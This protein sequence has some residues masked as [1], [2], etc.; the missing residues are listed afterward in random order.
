MQ[1]K[2][3]IPNAITACNLLSGIVGLYFAFEGRMEAAFIMML[4]AGAFD[5]LDGFAARLLGVQSPVGAELDSLS[6]VVSFGVLPA[7]ML[8]LHVKEVSA[9]HLLLCAIP[10]LIAV[11]SAIRL[12]KFNTDD[13]QHFS[14]LGLPTPGAAILCG[15]IAA[16]CAARPDS[17]AAHIFS[18]WWAA[19]VLS[20]IVSVLLVCEIPFFSFKV[21]R[22]DE[23]AA[24][25]GMKRTCFF[26]I[27]AVAVIIAVVLSWHWTAIPA[28]IVSSYILEN[29]ILRIFRI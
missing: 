25:Q 28:G 1:I 6:D 27:S 16:L 10:L 29:L 15:S 24:V 18:Y 14:F 22:N 19:A 3:H 7:A 4:A 11:F 17:V 12:A 8:S 26:C 2:Q 13:R 20:G 21:N 9:A 5:F 23:K